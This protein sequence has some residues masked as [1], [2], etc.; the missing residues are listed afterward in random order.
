M[1]KYSL[2]KLALVTAVS[3]V[4]LA[5][6]V[7]AGTPM[8]RIIGGG[9]ATPNTYPWMVSIQSKS[10]S[11]HFCGGSLIGESYI[12]TAAHCIEDASAEEIQAVVSEFDLK[13]ASQQ[14]Q[15][16]AI[17]NI[18]MHQGYGDDNDI[19]VLELI[20]PTNKTPVKL[21]DTNLNDGLQV[22][23]N[24][25]VMGW[26]NQLADG[27]K[28]PNTL[29]E[30]QLPLA[31]HAQ[32]KSNYA[33]VDMTITDNM[34]CAGLAAG[35]KDSCQGDSGGPLVYQKDSDWFQTGVVSFG[36]GCA[37]ENFFGVYTKVSNYNDWIAQVKAGEVPVHQ[38]S[39]GNGDNSDNEESPDDWSDEDWT[40]EDWDNQDWNDEDYTDGNEGE[41]PEFETEGLAFDLP[42]YVGFLA[43]G[44]DLVVEEAVY[45][46]NE[47]ESPLSVQS[48]SL[49]NDQQFSIIENACEAA[50]L[51]PEEEC[52][53]T[54]GF[55]S[56]DSELHQANLNISTSDAE[57]TSIDIALFGI[58]LDFLELGDDFDGMEG[59]EGEEWYFDGDN[60]W[61]GDVESGEFDL[62][63]DAVSENDDAVLMT[64]IEGP[65]T[66]EFDLNLSGDVTEN[67]MSFMV[68]GELVMTLSSDRSAKKHSV[69]LSDG[70]HQVSWVY[71]KT[72]AND[73]SAKATISNVSFKSSEEDDASESSDGSDE[74]ATDD[75]T[76]DDEVNTELENAISTIADSVSGAGSTDGLLLGLMVLLGF[77]LRSRKK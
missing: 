70:E 20:T 59:I 2:S 38:P 63:C 19:A 43:P 50:T 30:V 77:S 39:E 9:D 60:A 46:F 45:V 54:L 58:A 65:G 41:Y 21:A 73:A 48:V 74:E 27:E 3:A 28:F 1:M 31:D 11:E 29:Q 67:T 4:A 22:G 56:S 23:T 5:N 42:E 68:D 16:I 75:E 57:H 76:T 69:E 18:Y 6:T 66:L 44:Q 64:E 61:T 8:A 51:K 52:E 34:L 33:G 47:G 72:K 25:T 15:V 35:G 53:I 40:D 7:N 17:K 49:D 13:Q 10:D 24:M 36:E 37:Q 32:C 26:G 62:S 14:E 71:S 12:L 55:V